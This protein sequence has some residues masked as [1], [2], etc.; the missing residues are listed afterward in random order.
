MI[1]IALYFLL[2]S[3]LMTILFYFKFLGLN[4]N[5]PEVE[6]YTSIYGD[7]LDKIVII[8]TIIFAGFILPLHL[9]QWLF[10]GKGWVVDN[11]K[12]GQ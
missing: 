11:D 4:H 2:S 7:N 12:S 5:D 8:F 3:L 6:L 9:Y 1:Y 10:L